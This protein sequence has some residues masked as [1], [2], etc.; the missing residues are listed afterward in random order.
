[1]KFVIVYWT[2][3][4]NNKKIVDYLAVKLKAKG[5]VH[6]FKTDEADPTAMPAADFYIF[7]AAA[8][9][10][11]VQKDMRKLMKKLKGMDGKK[12]GI[13]NTHGSKNKNWLAPMAK[14]LDKKNMVKVAETDFAVEGSIGSGTHLQEGWEAKL[15]AFADKL[16]R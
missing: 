10:F 7:S 15:D 6:V 2:R 16:S 8:E 5:E 12:Y 11:M 3:Y 14:I 1:M 4:G 9:K 13:I